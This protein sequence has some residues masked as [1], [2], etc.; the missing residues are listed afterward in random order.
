ML[1]GATRARIVAT[2]VGEQ[3][4][5]ARGVNPLSCCNPCKAFTKVSFACAR[6][7]MNA[8]MRLFTHHK[9]NQ[10]LLSTNGLPL[11]FL[12]LDATAT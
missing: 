1:D 7:M 6:H 9:T 8:N 2:E 10:K 4:P 3:V 5:G 12:L 11:S